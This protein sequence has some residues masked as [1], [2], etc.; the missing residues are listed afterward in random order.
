V[1]GSANS[2]IDPG[3]PVQTLQGIAPPVPGVPPVPTG[4]A[5]SAASFADTPPMPPVA[6]PPP[7]VPIE[8]VEPPFEMP[9]SVWPPV[10]LEEHA[11]IAAWPVASEQ[12]RI[13]RIVTPVFHNSMSS[14]SRRGSG[15]N[16]PWHGPSGCNVDDQGTEPKYSITS[17][18]RQET[19]APEV[20]IQPCYERSTH[21]R[22]DTT[23]IGFPPQVKTKS[24]NRV[25]DAPLIPS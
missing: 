6:P 4:W 14:S 7:P 8:T 1:I 5:S 22:S 20:W 24:S 25:G 23:H 21:M 15:G 3:W 12:H 2:A 17:Q 11:A 10:P 9:A 18:T 13:D 19:V 16:V